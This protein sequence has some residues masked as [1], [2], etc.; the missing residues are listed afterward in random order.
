MCVRVCSSPGVDDWLLL[1]AEEELAELAPRDFLGAE[2]A[3]AAEKITQITAHAIKHPTNYSVSWFI[4][5]CVCVWDLQ[6][7]TCF[8]S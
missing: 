5:T 2:A 3:T 4:G 7:L 6:T 8:G 1:Q